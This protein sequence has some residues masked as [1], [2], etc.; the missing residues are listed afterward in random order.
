MVSAWAADM[1]MLLG[2]RRVD[3]KSN[4]ITAIPHLLDLLDVQGCTVTIDC[5]HFEP[6]SV[7]DIVVTQDSLIDNH[8][9]RFLEEL[10]IVLMKRNG[11]TLLNR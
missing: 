4:E 2:Q 8:I 3:G 5:L 7:G 6:F 1:Q 11:D 10:F 9:R